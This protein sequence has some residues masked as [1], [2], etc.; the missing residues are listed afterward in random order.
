VGVIHDVKQFTLSEAPEH[1]LYVSAAQFPSPYMSIVVRTSR[2]APQLARAIRD[3]V[4]AVDREQPVSKVRSFD[5]L[6]T[7]Q[8]TLMRTTTQ[9][10]ALFGAVALL[11]GAVGIYGVMA[12]SVGQRIHEMGIRMALGGSPQQIVRL[13]LGQGL[14][15]TLTGVALGIIGA[16]MVTRAFSS[17]LY[18]V[19]PSDATTF[20]LVAA[21]FTVVA[22]GACYIPARRA[23]RV[24]PMV[25]LR[26]E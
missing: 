18:M 21:F 26:Y 13:V 2:P 19:K 9:M 12:H 1:Q 16:A 4:W 17:M 23:M 8:N 25:A 10:M 14:K 20:A 15:L 11:L 7:E 24:D 3:A 22:L 5:D 6:I